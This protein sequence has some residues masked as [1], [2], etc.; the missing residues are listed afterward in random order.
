MSSLGLDSCECLQFLSCL[1]WLRRS[2]RLYYSRRPL[3]PLLLPPQSDACGC[4]GLI[5]CPDTPSKTRRELSEVELPSGVIPPSSP[6]SSQQHPASPINLLL[7]WHDVRSSASR[8]VFCKNHVSELSR[9]FVLCFC[10]CRLKTCW[11]FRKL[12]HNVRNRFPRKIIK[13]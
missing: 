8:I 5:G 2:L 13:K 3:L 12:H 11:R 7:T 6:L 10:S 9:R 4:R 1:L